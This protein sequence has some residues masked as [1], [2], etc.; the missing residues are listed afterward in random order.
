MHSAAHNRARDL[1][2]RLARADNHV[3]VVGAPDERRARL[4]RQAVTAHCAAF[5]KSAEGMPTIEVPAFM[6]GVSDA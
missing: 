3:D 5:G 6:K 1:A 4:R 2:E